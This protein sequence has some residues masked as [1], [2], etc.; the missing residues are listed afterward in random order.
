M[1]AGT[2]RA[3]EDGAT[4][5]ADSRAKSG[6]PDYQRGI[7]LLKAAKL[8][9]DGIEGLCLVRNMSPSGLMAD[10]YF[11]VERGTEVIVML[12]EDVPMS[13]TVDWVR[14]ST[15]GIAFR[16]EIEVADVLA[17]F[18]R[19]VSGQRIRMPRLQV[20]ARAMLRLGAHILSVR[21]CDI[22]QGGARVDVQ[23][24][25]NVGI[26]AVIT[27]ERFHPVQGVIRWCRGSEAGVSFNQPLGVR[28][29]MSWL[30]DRPM[31]NAV[32]C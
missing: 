28:E 20:E 8:V 23:P 13:G 29:L 7:A 12:T 22:S 19:T 14:G 26:D 9:T 4:A 17:G 27:M 5:K 21:V 25:A 10:V 3:S 18:G 2:D 15:I 24:P 31:P 1:F 32:G 30:R 16:E 11:P 6:T